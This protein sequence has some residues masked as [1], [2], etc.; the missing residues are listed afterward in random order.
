MRYL[1]IVAPTAGQ[2]MQLLMC[3]LKTSNENMLVLRV[4]YES[5]KSCQLTFC[6]KAVTSCSAFTSLN[7]M[8]LTCLL[9]SPEK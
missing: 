1:L 6:S 3:F 7:F 2:M 8:S 9:E 5:V 4:W